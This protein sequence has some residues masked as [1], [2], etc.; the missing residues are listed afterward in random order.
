MG[1]TLYFFMPP[2]TLLIS[3]VDQVPPSSAPI[4]K[5]PIRI[6]PCKRRNPK[7]AV[8]SFAAQPG[9]APRIS[10]STNKS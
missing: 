4:M 5:L 1:E 2:Y 9:L 8:V 3:R 7:C 6:P 10:E